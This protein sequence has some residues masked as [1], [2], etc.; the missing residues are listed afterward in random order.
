MGLV[1]QDHENCFRAEKDRF[2]PRTAFTV[3]SGRR[4]CD[5]L[6]QAAAAFAAAAVALRGEKQTRSR[7]NQRKAEQFAKLLFKEAQQQAPSVYSKCG[8]GL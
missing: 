8:A 6:F 5:L 7:N 4:G 1:K 3:S 2:T